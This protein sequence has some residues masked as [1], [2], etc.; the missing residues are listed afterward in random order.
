[1]KKIFLF[2]LILCLEIKISA[3]QPNEYKPAM[4]SVI[5]PSPNAASL[6]QYGNVPISYYNGTTNINIPL[7]DI[8]LAGQKLP[9]SIGYNSSGIKVTQ[10]ASW[11]GLSWAL[12]AG[13]C[14][15]RECFGGDD[16]K[17]STSFGY[18]WDNNLTL[19]LLTNPQYTPIGTWRPEILWL[20]NTD[21]Q[22][23]IFHF[24]F[25]Q[26]SG[27]M[28]FEKGNP[29]PL[30]RNCKEYLKPLYNPEHKYWQI[31]DGNGYIYYFGRSEASRDISTGCYKSDR[32]EYN[33][34]PLNPV[35]TINDISELITQYPFESDRKSVV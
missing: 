15:T 2:M 25:G 6:G 5:P 4:S 7:H 11:V 30:I 1:M 17:E 29:V 19:D 3:Q 21:P 20:L 16:F 33:I 31:K 12:N 24:N 9:I 35:R 28:F 8:E 22:P 18:Y 13:G 27:S 34:T 10:E 26:Y 32:A 23:D 14:I